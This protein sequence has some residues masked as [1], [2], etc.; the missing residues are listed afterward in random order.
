ML[1]F[2]P[3][4]N[5]NAPSGVSLP[6]TFCKETS[7]WLKNIAHHPSETSASPSLNQPAILASSSAVWLSQWLCCCGSCL[8]TAT[9]A[10]KTAVTPTTSRLKRL[11]HLRLLTPSHQPRLIQSPRHLPIRSHPRLLTLSRLRPLTRH[12]PHLRQPLP[13]RN[14]AGLRAYT[15]LSTLGGH[16]RVPALFSFAQAGYATAPKLPTGMTLC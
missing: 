4:W 16:R 6:D 12:L 5:Q 14:T 11:S 13:T 7:S 2:A 9:W 8:A 3:L 10:R 15:D 1:G